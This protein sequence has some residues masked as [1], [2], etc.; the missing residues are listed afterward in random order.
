MGRHL[1]NALDTAAKPCLAL[2]M[3][4]QA[5]LRAVR[6]G[7]ELLAQCACPSPFDLRPVGANRGHRT[8][9]SHRNQCTLNPLHHEF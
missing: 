9:N 4:G 2:C 8:A 3:S 1:T 7:S 5:A 6:I